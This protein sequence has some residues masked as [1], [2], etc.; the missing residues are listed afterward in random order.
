MRILVTNDDGIG[1][2]GIHVLAGALHDAGHDVF[3]VAPAHDCSGAS[4]ALGRMHPDEHVEVTR[5]E[6]P[7]APEVEAWSLAGPP[8]LAVLAT[9]LGGFGDRRPDLV[10]SGVNAGLNTGRAILHS[11]TVGAVLTAQNFGLSGL[12]V[13]VQSSEQW[14]WE[15]AAALAVEALPLVADAPARTALNLNVP[16][17]P[18]QQVRGL[19]WARLAPFGEVRAGVEGPAHDRLQFV[20]RRVEMDHDEDTD[21]GLVQAGYASLT[22]LVGVVEAW[23]DESGLE[24]GPTELAERL[25]PGAP[26]HPVHRVPDPSNGGVLRRPRL[27]EG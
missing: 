16:A 20:L 13:S 3:V 4:C 18:R 15:T 21:Q 9:V 8:G 25:V 23:P 7:T 11:G 2:E 26:V 12:A 19:R 10:V 17:L 24:A 27:G 1:S 6:L 14:Y 5:V 22:T